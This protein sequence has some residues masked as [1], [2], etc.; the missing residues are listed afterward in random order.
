MEGPVQW[1]PDGSR[2]A[3]RASAEGT[4]GVVAAQYPSG[5]GVW[6]C[7]GA[8]V[9][10][11][12]WDAGGERMAYVTEEDGERGVWLQTLPPGEARRLGGGGFDLRW[13]AD[14]ESLRWLRPKSETV[15]V[16]ATWSA[17]TGEVTEANPQPA[18][19]EGAMW[20]PDGR[21]CAV[22]GP[23][24]TA[25]GKQLVI[26]PASSTA[27]EEVALPYVKPER[28]LGWS[29]DSRLIVVLGDLD[30]PVAVAASQIPE[31][32]EQVIAVRGGDA[33]G[34]AA[35]CGYPVDPEAGPP[36]WSS[37]CDMLAYVVASEIGEWLGGDTSELPT[38]CLVASALTRTHLGPPAAGE[39]EAQMV[40]SNVENVAFALQMYLADYGDVF[41]PSGESE[42]VWR[43]LDE[44][45][46]NRSVFMRPGT[47][48]EMVVQYLVPPGVRL[49]DTQDPV[50]LPVAVVDY[51][52]HVYIVAYADG[53]A[54]VHEKK[55]DYWQEL[56]APWWEYELQRG[57]EEQ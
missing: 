25:D 7:R 44:Y 40:L 48:D 19:P 15:W 11:L 6:V 55:G 20:S 3:V 1:A 39:A 14:G 56:A 28:L 22:L 17:A 4:S 31:G 33:P 5:E 10:E 49:V 45:V 47:E 57:E 52:P 42:E 26:H 23:G 29:P 24:R 2:I 12:A 43:I 18:R 9:V 37:R 34:R 16:E 41:P 50:R 46:K 30:F 54:A 21:L 36:S 13:S 27:G 51:L 35:I 53:H 32:Y 38:G 8:E